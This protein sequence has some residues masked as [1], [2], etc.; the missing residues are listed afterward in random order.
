MAR[1]QIKAN[2]CC[3]APV[4]PPVTQLETEGLALLAAAEA[5]GQLKGRYK[6][7]YASAPDL[8]VADVQV[9]LFCVCSIYSA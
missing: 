2:F 5:G 9:Y 8:R 6:Y 1:E 7:L 3:A 4:I